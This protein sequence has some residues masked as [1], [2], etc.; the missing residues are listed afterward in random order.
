MK[1][2]KMTFN[3]KKFAS[4]KGILSELDPK[5]DSGFSL[6]LQISKGGLN[7]KLKLY[8]LSFKRYKQF[9]VCNSQNVIWNF[10]IDVTTYKSN[11]TSNSKPLQFNRIGLNGLT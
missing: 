1:S 9:I 2:P 5:Q 11:F 10:K 4:E 8:E 6:N 3:S 7:K